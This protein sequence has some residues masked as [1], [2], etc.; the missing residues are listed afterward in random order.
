MLFFL[1]FYSAAV[2]AWKPDIKTYITAEK[3]QLRVL[4]LWG[5]QSSHIW[6]RYQTREPRFRPGENG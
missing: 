6:F 1:I 3:T 2:G 4:G 5:N